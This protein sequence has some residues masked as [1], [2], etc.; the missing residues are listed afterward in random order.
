[1]VDALSGRRVQATLG[2]GSA[3][4]PIRELFA[5]LPIALFVDESPKEP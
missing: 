3:G 1:L 2:N 5:A 4:L